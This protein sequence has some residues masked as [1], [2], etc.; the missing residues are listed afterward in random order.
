MK[1]TR[2]VTST[3][4]RFDSHTKP[5]HHTNTHTRPTATTIALNGK[6]KG[7]RKSSR[8]PQSW[9]SQTLNKFLM[10]KKNM[11]LKKVKR[12]ASPH[13]TFYYGDNCGNVT[14]QRKTQ[15]AVSFSNTS[16][17][18]LVLSSFFSFTSSH[19]DNPE[20]SSFC[21]VVR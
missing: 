6:K 4:L 11:K 15:H 17:H 8:N 14:P 16:E 3:W 18:T 2:I 9:S 10:K 7:K 19:T 20:S 12:V 21:C 13:R 1:L 5:A